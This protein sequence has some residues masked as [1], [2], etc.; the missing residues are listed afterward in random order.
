MCGAA[1][2]VGRMIVGG[3]FGSGVTRTTGTRTTRDL[4]METPQV[5][6]R[7]S[8][9]TAPIARAMTVA[10]NTCRWADGD[11]GAP[12]RLVPQTPQKLSSGS[13]GVPHW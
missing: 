13:S 8:S 7:Y 6:K 11:A 4:W 12:A 3:G 1:P 2:S 9:T 5:E 10:G